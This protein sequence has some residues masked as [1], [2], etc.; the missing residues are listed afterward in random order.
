M[1]EEKKVPFKPNPQ[2]DPN[3]YQSKGME[4]AGADQTAS[5]SKATDYKFQIG[6]MIQKMVRNERDKI[7]GFRFEQS[8]IHHE[9][10]S[11]DI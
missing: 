5:P 4:K 8:T 6:N 10:V 2:L 1:T 9:H 7:N 3:F 11:C